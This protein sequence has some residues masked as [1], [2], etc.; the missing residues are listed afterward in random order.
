[1]EGTFMGIARTALFVGRKE[2]IFVTVAG[3]RRKAN[4]LEV[5]GKGAI[6]TR[7]TM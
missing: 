7:R 5:R 1:M 4:G 2:P 6:G 3:N